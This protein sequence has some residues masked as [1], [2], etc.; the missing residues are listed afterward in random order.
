MTS[1]KPDSRLLEA[2]ASL[3]EIGA[4]VNQ[5][6]LN[7]IVSVETTLNLIVQ[8][9]IRVVPGASAVIYTYDVAQESFILTSR[10]SA[11]GKDQP[12]SGDEPRATGLGV[13]AIVQRRRVLS[14]EEKDIDIHPVR[15]KAGARVMGCFPL[16]VADQPVGALY[17]Y[18]QEERL[19]SQLELLMLDN[20]V[21]QAAMA[22]YHAHNLATMQH[23]LARKDEELTRLRRA[24][25]LISS[26]LRLEETLEA[27]LQMALEVT[28][29][30]Y[31]IFRLLDKSG[32]FLNTRAVGFTACLT[33]K[34]PSIIRNLRSQ[35]ACPVACSA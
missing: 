28:G 32:Q 35:R 6:G 19:F 13:R 15:L 9:A 11:G 18:L 27:I 1:P 30:H 25:L 26:R 16:I 21:N 5:I 4:T 14:Y 3:N 17:V 24:G 23:D 34:S 31:G 10:V 33:P 7:G 8:S 22:I 12:D 20:F 2:L 29:A